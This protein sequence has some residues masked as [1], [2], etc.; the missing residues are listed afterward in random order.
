[1]PAFTILQ[2]ISEIILLL[3]DLPLGKLFIP[4]TPIIHR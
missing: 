2:N 3:Y 4:M 1:M